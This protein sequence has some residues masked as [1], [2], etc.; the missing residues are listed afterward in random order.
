M[1]KD[2]NIAARILK[3][4]HHGSKYAT[5]ENFIKRVR[6]EV[7][8]ISNGDTN[9]YGHPS[10]PTLDRLRAAG[11]KVYR[12]DLH[13]EIAIT[14]KGQGGYEIKTAKEAKA[15][16]LWAGREAQKDDSARSGF[17]SYGDFGPPPREKKEKAAAR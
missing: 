7:A 5:S 10:Q 11:V 17:V 14:T 6:P 15:D 4:G 12:T 3:V 2:V 16:S 9:R 1:N 8:V 13:G